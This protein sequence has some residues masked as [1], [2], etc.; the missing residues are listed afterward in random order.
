MIFSIDINVIKRLEAILHMPD[1]NHK[2]HKLAQIF[3]IIELHK[4]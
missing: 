4:S 1:L 2:F 3:I